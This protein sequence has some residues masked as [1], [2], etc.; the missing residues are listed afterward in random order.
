VR[1]AFDRW[2]P[3]I[4]GAVL[5]AGVASYAAVRLTG[6]NAAPPHEKS[7][8]LPVERQVALEFVHTAVARKN[9]ARAWDLAAPELKR[10][11]TREEWLAG[12]MRVVPYPVAQATVTL[13][14]VS[15]FTDVAQFNV[16]FLPKPGTKA[17]PQTF[18]LDLRKVDGRWLAGAWTPSDHVRPHKGK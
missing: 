9:L 8:L 6:D 17:D 2:A 15:S 12:T 14:V 1:H 5:V 13:Q 11:T 3:W 10:D 4:A 7:T 18:L 16:T